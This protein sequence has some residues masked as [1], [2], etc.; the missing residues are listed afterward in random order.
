M[1]EIDQTELIIGL[2]SIIKSKLFAR[3]FLLK[4]TCKTNSLK[5]K[6]LEKKI[7]ELE[8]ILSNFYH[9]LNLSDIEYK[10]LLNKI[11]AYE[12]ID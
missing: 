6:N 10:Q 12:Q 7:Q 8:I 5:I 9:Q 1:N 2:I 11:K 4:K 3:L